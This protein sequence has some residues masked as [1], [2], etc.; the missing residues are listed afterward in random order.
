IPRRW[1]NSEVISAA[2]QRRGATVRVIHEDDF[3]SADRSARAIVHII[4]VTYPRVD[5]WRSEVKDPFDIWFDEHIPTFDA[6]KSDRA[7]EESDRNELAR[8][9]Q[10]NSIHELVEAYTEEHERM[11][12]NY[13][14]IFR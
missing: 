2:I 3:L 8:I 12:E 13:R 7:Q 5:D 6:E 14:A 11:E 9:R 10:L 1:K 4:E